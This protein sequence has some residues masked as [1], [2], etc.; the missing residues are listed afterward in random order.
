MVVMR[1][2]NMR[3]NPAVEMIMVFRM[4]LATNNPT[5]PCKFGGNTLIY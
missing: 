1:T 4:V 5:G 3:R 2:A